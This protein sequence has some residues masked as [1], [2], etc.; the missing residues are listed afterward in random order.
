MQNYHQENFP[1]P[2]TPYKSTFMSS[3]EKEQRLR[4]LPRLDSSD[5]KCSSQQSVELSQ[6][7]WWYLSP[8]MWLLLPTLATD[9]L[10]R[11]VC[12]HMGQFPQD[13][14]WPWIMWL[15]KKIWE[16]DLTK[17][18]EQ[19]FFF[20]WLWEIFL[21]KLLGKNPAYGRHQL[22]QPMLIEAPIQNNPDKI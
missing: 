16:V 7:Q 3:G 17:C 1:F 11:P 13:G 4:F 15:F 18:E 6:S 20:N 22:S 5:G 2:W 12:Y 21:L 10:P 8:F 14:N 9:W 19:P